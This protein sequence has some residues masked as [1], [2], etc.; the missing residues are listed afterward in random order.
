MI[1]AVVLFLLVILGR[2]DSIQIGFAIALSMVASCV[3][4]NAL[5]VGYSR[6]AGLRGVRV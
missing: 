4:S 6:C 2:C 3:D 5:D 1:S